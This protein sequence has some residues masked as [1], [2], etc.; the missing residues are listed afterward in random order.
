MQKKSKRTR[1]RRKNTRSK[2]Q[3]SKKLRRIIIILIVLFLLIIFGTNFYNKMQEKE[4]QEEYSAIDSQD[5]SYRV[6][7]IKTGSSV[8]DMAKDLKKAGL[9]RTELDFSKY[10]LDK[11]GSGL[12]A[13]TYYLQRSQSIPQIYS[14]LVKGPNTD[15]YR[16]L[17]IKKRV[18]YAKELQKKYNVLASI[19]IAQTILESDWGTSTLASKYNNYYGIKAQGNQKSIQLDTKEY[20]NGKWVTEKDKFAVYS[21]WLASMLAHAKFIAEGTDANSTQFKDV[22]SAGDYTEA[23]KALVTDGYATDPDYANKLISLIK[24]YKLNQYDN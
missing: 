9:V 8:Q 18:K 23:A 13:G 2:N 4:L 19:D 21:S 12:Q 7:V 17:F 6:V 14:R 5:K 3:K 11:G 10:A 16:Q 24:T 1:T 22:L 15:V 20:V